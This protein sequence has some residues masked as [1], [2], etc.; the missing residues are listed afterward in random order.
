MDI[1][2]FHLPGLEKVWTSGKVMNLDFFFVWKF[3]EVS[4]VMEN[5][6]EPWM[7]KYYEGTQ[8][9]LKEKQNNPTMTF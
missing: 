4:L 6:W 2:K 7:Q 8:E 9:Q 5:A 1:L 3:Y